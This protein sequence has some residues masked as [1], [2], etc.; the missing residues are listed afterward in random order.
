MIR[1]VKDPAEVKHESSVWLFRGSA[2]TF[3]LEL[4]DIEVIPSIFHSSNVTSLCVLCENNTAS[5]DPGIDDEHIRNMLA[6]P[7]YLQER[8]ASA[9][10]SQV[11]QSNEESLLP[12]SQSISISAGKPVALVSQKR[13]SRQELD[14]DRIRMLLTNKKNDYSLKQDPKL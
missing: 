2:L 11:Y 9:D 5:F 12:S 7:L 8:E 1:A 14:N 4:D 10:L 3:R 6:S 13:K